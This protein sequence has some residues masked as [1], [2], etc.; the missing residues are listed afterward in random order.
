MTS[1]F[2]TANIHKNAIASQYP[3]SV[4]PVWL[5]IPA[6]QFF[7]DYA[8]RDTF[9]ENTNLLAQEALIRPY[10]FLRGNGE[11]KADI[12]HRLFTQQRR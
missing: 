5:S 3:L 2:L 6:L 9:R 8:L 11:C 7:G 1:D 4:R 10:R 12:G